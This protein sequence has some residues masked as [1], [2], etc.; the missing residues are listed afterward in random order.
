MRRR[1]GGKPW[2]GER[3][4]LVRRRR[5]GLRRRRRDANKS[6]S[7]CGTSIQLHTESS[8]GKDKMESVSRFLNRNR[9]SIYNRPAIPL[10]HSLPALLAALRKAEILKKYSLPNITGKF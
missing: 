1:I 10:S 4:I 5:V 2:E 3:K 6:K 8:K 9:D 7:L